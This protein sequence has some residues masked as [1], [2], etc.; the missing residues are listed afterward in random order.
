METFKPIKEH[1]EYE[2]SNFGNIQKNGKPLKQHYNSKYY[3][4]VVINNKNHLVHRLVANAFIPNPENK[5][6]VNHIDGNNENNN[7][8][9]LEWVTYIENYNHVVENGLATKSY[10]LC[11]LPY[12]VK[13]LAK[14]MTNKQVAEMLDIRI[15][16]VEKILS[17]EIKPLKEPF[18]LSDKT[19][20]K[21]NRDLKKRERRMAKLTP[22]QVEYIKQ[23]DCTAQELAMEF[24]VTK[25]TINRILH[26]KS[27]VNSD[28]Y[29]LV[30]EKLC[31]YLLTFMLLSLNIIY[32]G[33]TQ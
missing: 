27:W 31:Q 33:G 12:S 5:Q 29:D 17:G 21:V 13:Y 19:K 1:P 28:F 15:D 14:T 24:G 18:G 32:R 26:G 8:D 3:K 20:F 2:V 25:T 9:N 30:K 6:Q 22:E 4:L 23:S 16:T 7:V 11:H 10:R